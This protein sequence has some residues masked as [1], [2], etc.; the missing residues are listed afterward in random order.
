MYD[1]DYGDLELARSD[2]AG[3]GAG[4][5]ACLSC[6]ERSCSGAC[7]FGVEI[8]KLTAPTHRRLALRSATAT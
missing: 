5:E 4:A 3:L 7:P 1:R 6:A 8:E 2:Y